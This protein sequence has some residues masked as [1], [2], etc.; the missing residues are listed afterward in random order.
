MNRTKLLQIIQKNLDE[1][2]EINQEMNCDSQPSKFEVELAL[3]KAKMLLQEYEFLQEICQQGS[4]SGEVTE[5]KKADE[6][7]QKAEPA[8]QLRK[9]EK[10]AIQTSDN[11]PKPPLVE[12]TLAK[13]PAVEKKETTEKAAEED[14]KV[15]VEIPRAEPVADTT[16]EEPAMQPEKVTEVKKASEPVKQQVDPPKNENATQK[17]TV[18]D[19]FVSKSLND[20]LTAS[21]KLDH[22][23]ASSPIAKLE[24]AIG[25]NDRFQYIRELFEND[26]DLFRAT[27]S[28]L[29]RM[30]TI[31][32]A[33]EH[34]DT[35][36]NWEKTD[37]SLQFMHLVKRRF[38][39]L[40]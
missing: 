32:E 40:Y 33:I 15:E 3:N 34:L 7:P 26:A 38:S 30:H 11:S 28:K 6:Q 8:I 2:S 25:L 39:T 35:K 9:R 24:N 4:T 20:L 27:I 10:E 37:T 18:T 17:K 13:E 36:F 14:E 22:R 16:K 31:E 1:L 21:N 23:F 19:Q 5:P 29:D 12:E